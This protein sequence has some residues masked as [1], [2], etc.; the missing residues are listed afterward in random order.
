MTPFAVVIFLLGLS[1]LATAANFTQVFEWPNELDFEWPSEESRTQALE[2]GTFKPVK[3]QPRYMAVYEAR[4]FLNLF[5]EDGV[6]ASLVSLP[7]S[8]ESSSPPKLTPFPSWDF[9][10]NG[11]GNCDK[12]HRAEGMEVDSD[13]RLWVLD[14]GNP[15]SNCSSK[16]WIFNLINNETELIHRFSFDEYFHDLVLDETANGTFAY[17][18]RWME[19]HVVVFSLER[20]E[21]WIVDTP[22]VEVNSIALS[23]K[24]Q[25]PR[26]LYLARSGFK[27]LYSIPVAALHNGNRTTEPRLIENW[28]ADNSYRMLMDSHGTLY[29]GFMYE[30]YT[31]TWNT[32]RPFLEQSFYQVAG[33]ESAWPFTFSL[34]QNATF[35][36]TVF[37]DVNMPRFRLLKAA[38][39]AKSYIYNSPGTCPLD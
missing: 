18:A 8:S 5:K 26:H 34:D 36:M 33:L 21:S 39:A 10:L 7:T 19:S 13:G 37:D 20:N 2:D 6:P 14:Q 4:L 31:S 35:W 38:V 29:S 24:D 22:K 9:H 12:I 16:L 25:E 23:T 17:I 28:A 27:E 11:S 15:D 32:S 30:N 3:I 1:S